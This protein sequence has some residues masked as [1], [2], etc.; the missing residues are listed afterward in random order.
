[1]STI[2]LKESGAALDRVNTLLAG[3]PKK[4]HTA[5]YN[6]ADRAAKHGKTVAGR[7]AA[8]VYTISKSQWMSRTSVTSKVLSSSGSVVGIQVSFAGGMVPLKEFTLRAT[9]GGIVAQVKRGGGGKIVRGFHNRTK[10]GV[11]EAMQR[12]GKS[13]LPIRRLYAL[14]GGSMMKNEEIIEKMTEEMDETFSK[15]LDHEILRIMNGW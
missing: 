12:E 15:R 7:H 10:G 5:A 11:Y 2:Q 14:G 6:A 8:S 9:Q 1:M 4:A 13:R 3:F